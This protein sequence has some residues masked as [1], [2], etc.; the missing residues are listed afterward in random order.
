MRRYA[1]GTSVP[2]ERSRSEIERTLERFGASK[3]GY[4]TERASAVIVFEVKGR[5]VRMRLELPDPAPFLKTERGKPRSNDAAR[6]EWEAACRSSWRSLAL[7]VKAKLVAIEDGIATF[8]DE[9]LA[10]LVLPSGET[11]AEKL[12]PQ[13]ELATHGNGPL[14]LGLSPPSRG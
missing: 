4:V 6:K 9:W 13:L 5:R 14:Q 1:S 7:I 11:V 8:E 3:F 12:A 2:V 10:Y